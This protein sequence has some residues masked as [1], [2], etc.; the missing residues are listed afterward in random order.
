MADSHAK[1]AKLRSKIDRAD[2]ELLKALGGRMKIVLEIARYKK[3]HDL[4]LV[5]KGRWR[6]LMRDRMALAESQELNKRFTK[7]LFDLI[8]REALRLQ[9]K[10]K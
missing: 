4:P 1:L 8:H 7:D 10:R 3:E 2:R 6:Q 9:R 5:Q